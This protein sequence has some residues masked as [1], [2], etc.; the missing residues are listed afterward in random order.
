[1]AVD[2]PCDRVQAFHPFSHVGID[3]AGPLAMCENKFRKARQ[4]KE[5]V[6]VFVC[7]TVKAIHLEVVTELST[8]AFLS[9]F[10]RFVTLRGL[11]YAFFSDCGTNLVGAAKEFRSLFAVAQNQDHVTAHSSCT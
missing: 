10:D 5:Y 1:M 3:F 7:V 9:S 8:A 6:A 11:P 4:Y 2:L